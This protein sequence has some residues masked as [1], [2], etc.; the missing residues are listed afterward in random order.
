MIGKGLVAALLATLTW[1]SLAACRQLPPRAEAAAPPKGDPVRGE[2]LTTIFACQEC[3]TLRQADGMHLDRARLFA[4]GIPFAGPWGLVHSANVSIPAASFPDRVLEDAIRGR[5]AWKFQMPTD[6]YRGMADDDMRDVV[7]FIKTLRPVSQPLP[8]NNFESAYTPPG[9]L[10][11]VSVP[12][13]APAPGTPERGRYLA[14]V[15]ICQDCHSP[16]AVGDDGDGTGL[17][18]GYDLRH[19]FGGGGFAFRFRDGRWLIPPNLTP[20]PV[21]G[22]GG[23]SEA[24]IVKAVRTGITP[25]GRRLNP[26]MPYAVA[27]HV[28]TDQDATDIARFLRSLPPVRSGRPRNPRFVVSDPPPDCCFVPPPDPAWSHGGAPRK[29]SRR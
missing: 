15:A 5:L 24:D 17:D 19:L 22:I 26:M 21:S 20:D 25:D 16:R 9:P 6:L 23:W 1:G 12:E 3:H 11:D 27:F 13:R 7:A 4:G 29:E 28:M 10:A 18:A 8:E 2:Y 14:R